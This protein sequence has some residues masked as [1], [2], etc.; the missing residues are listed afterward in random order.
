MV[1]RQAD[2]RLG[3]SQL[4]CPEEL[5]WAVAAIPNHKGFFHVAF[6]YIQMLFEWF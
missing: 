3:L 6:E 1:G 4:E 5:A 2:C